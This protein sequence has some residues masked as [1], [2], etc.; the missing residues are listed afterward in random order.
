MDSIMRYRQPVYDLVPDD[1][2]QIVRGSARL[3]PEHVLVAAVGG[4]PTLIQ[5]MASADRDC[6]EFVLNQQEG[7]FFGQT[8][9]SRITVRTS[10]R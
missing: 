8:S 3:T 9:S 1:S 2:P 7:G 10:K 5:A 6:V 4:L